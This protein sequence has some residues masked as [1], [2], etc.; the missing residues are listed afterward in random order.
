MLLLAALA[1][2]I[3]AYAVSHGALSY[4]NFGAPG[5]PG[6]PPQTN[7]S[8]VVS[9]VTINHSYTV[10]GSETV[11][12]TVYTLTAHSSDTTRTVTTTVT[13]TIKTTHSSTHGP[14]Q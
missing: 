5:N 11:T 7:N 10:T 6:D 2:G 14:G 3:V 8:T 1:F 4:A 9:Y 13:V 12:T